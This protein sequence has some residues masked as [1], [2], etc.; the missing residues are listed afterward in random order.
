[1][2]QSRLRPPPPPSPGPMLSLFPLARHSPTLNMHRRAVMQHAGE[3]CS[4]PIT[5]SAGDCSYFPSSRVLRPPRCGRRRRKKG[6]REEK[7]SDA[8]TVNPIPLGREKRG[9]SPF[10]SFVLRPLLPSWGASSPFT[11]DAGSRRKFG[12]NAGRVT[13]ARFKNILRLNCLRCAPP[14]PKKKGEF[15]AQFV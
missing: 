13:F 8:G 1:M 9:I 15:N 2:T 14:P 12:H 6:R 11:R 10:S 7:E 3:S 4:S 5:Q